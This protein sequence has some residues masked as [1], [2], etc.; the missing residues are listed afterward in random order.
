MH[1]ARLGWDAGWQ[2]SLDTLAADAGEGVVVARVCRVDAGACDLMLPGETGVER[3]TARWSARLHH[4]AADDP[5]TVPAT[6]DW[7][8][9]EPHT[10]AQRS[11]PWAVTA[12]LPRRTALERLGVSGTSDGQVLAANAD[13]VAVV[14]GMVPD[15]DLG[16]LERL[17]TLAWSSGARPAVL[18]T[19]ADL[20]PDPA[21]VVAMVTESAAGCDVIAVAAPEGRGLDEPRG[22]LAEGATVALL[23]ASGVGKSTLL[24]ALVGEQAMATRSLGVEG[25][26]RHT[27][28]TRELHL[29]PDGGAVLDTP[30]LRSVGLRGDEAVDEVFADVV[31]LADRCRFNDCTHTVEPGCAVL[32]A[33]DDGSLPERRLASWRALER[34]AAFQ[35]RRSD[36]RLQ[37]EYARV[38]KARAKAYRARP[39][40]KR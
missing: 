23:G 10:G 34:E 11:A 15:L 31:D 16:R 20:H 6:G 21:E 40:K 25:K 9:I 17:L 26:G 8:L 27:T 18:L 2:H 39:D 35:A 12:L 28:V 37:A 3:V 29:A 5:T 32:A 30:G 38:W 19:K 33:V 1:A 13:V 22:W 14:E 7:A 24:N 4:D 36:A